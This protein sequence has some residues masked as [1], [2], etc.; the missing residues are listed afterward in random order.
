[1]KKLMTMI[2]AVA[3]A[4]GLFADEPQTYD[5]TSFETA[6]GVTDLTWTPSSGY[7]AG[8]WSTAIEGA[9]DLGAYAGDAYVYPTSAPRRDG[10]V[11]TEPRAF[12][13][14][15]ANANYLKLDTGSAT[16]DRAVANGQ[17]FFDQ[18]I[19]FTGFE[20]MQTNFVD[21]T[22]IALWTSAIE[23]DEDT[24]EVNEA[25]TNLYVAVGTGTDSTN[26]KIDVS[27]LADD[28][29]FNAWHRVT[30]KNAGKV[31]GN[32]LGFFVWIDG[33][34]A[35]IVSDEREYFNGQFSAFKSYYDKGQLFISMDGDSATVAN[36]G[37]QGVGSLDDVVV[38]KDG[39]AFAVL[40]VDVTFAAMAQ[41]T[42]VKVVDED[43]NEFTDF[44]QP[45]SVKPGQLTVTLAAKPGWILKNATK[46]VD[47]KDAASG[48]ITITLTEED[49][50]EAVA[51][52]SNEQTGKSIDVA[53]AELLEK[54]AQVQDGDTITILK[55]CSVTNGVEETPLYTFT[56]GTTV[57]VAAITDG[58]KW[59]INVA[60]WTPEGGEEPE[61]G[62]LE[63]NVGVA[64]EK[65]I[66]VAFEEGE[67]KL[68]FQGTIG[69]AGRIGSV[70][71]VT[72][73]SFTLSDNITVGEDATLKFAKIT[74]EKKIT[75]S[76]GAKVYS[77][78]KLTVADIFTNENVTDPE[79]KTGDFYVYELA[80]A[81]KSGFMLLI[82]G[83]ETYF[84]LLADAI[85]A[86]SDGD[87]ITAVGELAL[88]KGIYINKNMFPTKGLTIDLANT[89][90]LVS[91]PGSG[92][93]GTETQAFHIESGNKVTIKDG[94]IACPE[95]MK[96]YEW[97]SDAA[98]DQ[99]G[100][101][102]MINN[103][104]E[105]TLNNV[106]VDASN[107]AKSFYGQGDA[108]HAGTA[109]A[110][111]GKNSGDLIL[112]GN[113][114]I[115]A[116]EAVEGYASYAFDTDTGVSVTVNGATI[117]G[118]VELAAG[119][120]TLTAGTLN[121]KLVAGADNLGTVTKEAGFTAAAPDGYKWVNGVLT[122][123]D[124]ATLTIKQ[125]DNCTV[126]VSNAENTAEIKT[127]AT[128]DKDLAVKL[129]VY[130]VAAEGYE[131]D[132]CA[133]TEQ[134][135]M[136][137]DYEAT[138]VVKEKAEEPVVDPADAEKGDIVISGDTATITLKGDATEIRINNGLDLNE[139][140]VPVQ[141]K[142]IRGVKADA[143]KVVAQGEDITAAFTK[144]G[145]G[146]TG[147]V[148]L[149]LNPAASVTLKDGTEVAVTPTIGENVEASEVD[150]TAGEIAVQA[151]PGL[152]YELIRSTKLGD[153]S[154]EALADSA[155]AETAKVSLTDKIT[156][157]KPP[158]AFYQ[159]KV[160]AK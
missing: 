136:T 51:N 150:I 68:K 57:A 4:F 42:I 78:Q 40:T 148:Q 111:S 16:V 52:I 15:T 100:I 82:S 17:V 54:V 99:K 147:Y 32:Y 106:A 35:T 119:N 89:T 53:E 91:K 59:T 115:T 20:D 141:L 131:L 160:E 56:P 24:E 5:G 102:R 145:D 79:E 6:E 45:I 138:A 124:Y 128:F 142:Q 153:K 151:I 159:I 101:S 108:R 76:D 31:S 152:T 98:A 154:T 36:I 47:T 96:N 123:I 118:D 156:G 63:V 21:G 140:Q 120:L 27:L 133:A 23:D 73:G 104:G 90:Y 81:P 19:K 33:K 44:T 37:F 113:S 129:N 134:V 10:S 70:L 107:M 1:M 85:A 62:E 110:V 87:T 125:V 97:G 61:G 126:V 50:V 93:S 130:R 8:V 143:I 66:T 29:D 157:E 84:P 135:T 55:E 28:F 86:A 30:I 38:S 117:N 132:G 3:T 144:T 105:L 114:S 127:G 122:K 158:A 67:G 22:K 64:P 103:Y 39:P 13:G 74:G 149:E 88:Q 112:T 94:T 58:S 155:K 2:A 109:Y 69:G 14:G 83:V 41:A 71:D 75:L 12:A 43:D 77:K 137:D 11:A 92:D 60:Q 80:T 9:L 139:V 116:R 65:Q 48:V 46:I 95:E 25:D 18:V 49:A 26:V 7:P 121:G 146:S 72:N 34:M